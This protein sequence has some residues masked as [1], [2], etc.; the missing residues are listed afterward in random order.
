[1]GKHKVLGSGLVLALLAFPGALGK[2]VP[3]ALMGSKDSFFES[4]FCKSY[5][6]EHIAT[7]GR[8][9]KYLAKYSKTSD[10][11]DDMV[12][13]SVFRNSDREIVA[14][15]MGL[16]AQDYEI[17]EFHLDLVNTLTGV[18]WTNS[19]I[20]DQVGTGGRL[21][22][23]VSSADGKK[24][25]KIELIDSSLAFCCAAD[26]HFRVVWVLGAQPSSKGFQAANRV[27]NIETVHGFTGEKLIGTKKSL[28]N[29]NF[30]AT[31]G[32]TFI[33]KSKRNYG[34]PGYSDYYYSLEKKGYEN[35]Y[36]KS[37][38]LPD[39]TLESAE[40]IWYAENPG[41]WDV[42]KNLVLGT[43]GISFEK[44]KNS[45]NKFQA[46]GQTSLPT[47]FAWWN[48]DSKLGF[49]P[50]TKEYYFGVGLNIFEPKNPNYCQCPH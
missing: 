9:N 8:T 47:R 3:K 12:E 35:V 17:T 29:G 24:R 11:P 26:I 34:W 39:N 14:V 44:A 37:S 2:D 49:S 23:F 4:E 1:M 41:I 48:L 30:C 25:F 32:C 19:E 46:F 6:C 20:A 13:I 36:L 43:T 10:S 42:Q 21:P 18:A 33:S 28:L 16:R 5:K 15:D 40:L 31:Y 7:L 27:S 50:A 45:K 38:R 22:D